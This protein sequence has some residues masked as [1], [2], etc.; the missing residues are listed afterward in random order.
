MWKQATQVNGFM[1]DWGSFQIEKWLHGHKIACNKE[2]VYRCMRFNW[3]AKERNL[4][5]V[6]GSRK[7]DIPVS[8][9][10]CFRE[11]VRCASMAERM[12]EREFDR[13]TVY[14]VPGS[15]ID[16]PPDMDVVPTSLRD[17]CLVFTSFNLSLNVARVHQWFGAASPGP[18]AM[19]DHTY[20]AW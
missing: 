10:G 19:L 1:L 5:K 17:V 6:I 2:D 15:Y 8:G 13:D 4:L 3:R 7:H 16:T 9:M 11:I 20:K 18:V 14:I 12:K